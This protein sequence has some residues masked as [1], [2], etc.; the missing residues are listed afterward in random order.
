MHQRFHKGMQGNNGGVERK[1]KGFS[2]EKRPGRGVC[3]VEK[4]VY[5]GTNFMAFL[6][7]KNK[8]GRDRRKGLC[9]Q[10]HTISV[11]GQMA[12]PSGFSLSKVE[13]PGMKLR[14]T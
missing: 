12:S 6:P 8:G 4:E 7:G 1:P 3:G 11:P 10:M 2:L 9:A 13:Q 5:N 14:D